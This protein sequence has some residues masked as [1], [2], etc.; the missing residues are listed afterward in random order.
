MRTITYFAL[1]VQQHPD[2]QPFF[3]LKSTAEQ[4]LEWADVPR[5]K[6]D[7][8][9]GYQRE[10]GDRH[11]R[12]RDFL[13]KDPLNVIPGAVIIATRAGQ[14]DIEPLALPNTPA[15]TL[16]K[17]TIRLN[18]KPFNQLLQDTYEAFLSRLSTEERA[19]ALAAHPPAESESND[20]DAGEDDE[21]DDAGAPDSYFAILTRE[22]HQACENFGDLPTERQKAVQDYI[23][24]TSKPGLIL[25]GQHRVFG[26]KEVVDH[27]IEL[28]VVL[29]PDLPAQEQVFHFYVL[30]NKAVPLKPTEL[31]GTIST[32]LTNQEIQNL[33]E[34]FLQSGV[35][36]E[37]ARWTHRINTDEQSPFRGM[38]DFGFKS[39]SAFIP[40]NV[41]FQVV[42]KFMK[43]A[44][45]FRL[46]FNDVTEWNQDPDFRMKA[47]FTVWGA[48]KHRYPNAWAK[49]QA[50]GPK[51]DHH[52]LF[53][54]A[55][56]LVLQELLFERFALD[57]PKR[58]QTNKNSPF[59]DLNDLQSSVE[60]ELHY[61][62]EEFFTR[63]WMETGLDT[64]ERRG[65]LL[66]QM[67][68]AIDKLG[69]KIGTLAL[70]KAKSKGNN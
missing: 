13:E 70:F 6:A 28:P 38:I 32:S 24:G 16:Y 41:M 40:E 50:N 21:S 56:M 46:V 44:K 58:K 45:R 8:M 4:L 33:Y 25:D 10:L 67:K 17:L 61:L 7:Y 37:E 35:K 64:S 43:P 48:I 51:G 2:S 19:D 9:A 66:G 15:N 31:R 23:E 26:A 29:M 20:S 59:S 3:L 42:S 36:A 39:A 63:T 52:P 49:G 27:S 1:K 62:P 54:K 5:K 53:M 69:E 14:V 12:I 22:L 34:R 11:K 68:A 55:T 30:N 47:F 18:E 60:A 65:F 57:M